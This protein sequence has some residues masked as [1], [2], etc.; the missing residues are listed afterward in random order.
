VQGSLDRV[1]ESRTGA[2]APG[3]RGA[4]VG[5]RVSKS[6]VVTVA[7]TESPLAAEP[8]GPLPACGD[9]NWGNA[10]RAAALA[11]WIDHYNH[12]RLQT[13]LGGPIPM[14]FVVNNVS[15]HS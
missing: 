2:T 9:S 13:A 4:I 7:I 15:G 10:E 3:Q 8:G 14:E 6:C 12:G 11:P 1:S 5:D